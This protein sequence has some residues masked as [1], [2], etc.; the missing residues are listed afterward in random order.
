MYKFVDV[1]I[2]SNNTCQL[3]INKTINKQTIDRLFKNQSCPKPINFLNIRWKYLKS[4]NEIA[5]IIIFNLINRSAPS[6]LILNLNKKLMY[7]N[8]YYSTSL[9]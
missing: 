1:I 4:T 7:S 2:K 5:W 9:P 6:D 3:R 8:I